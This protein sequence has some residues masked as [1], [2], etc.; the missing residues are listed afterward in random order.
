MYSRL[1]S[2][3]LF[4]LPRFDSAWAQYG[5][6][7]AIFLFSIAIYYWFNFGGTFRHRFKPEWD[8]VPAEVKNDVFMRVRRL[9]KQGCNPVM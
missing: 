8:E 3:P 4:E 6:N 9:R 7:T 5:I 2:L 1:Q